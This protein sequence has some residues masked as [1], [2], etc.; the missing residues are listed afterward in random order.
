MPAP[1]PAKM[2]ANKQYEVRDPVTND[3]VSY[4]T[5]ASKMAVTNYTRFDSMMT[6]GVTKTLSVYNANLSHKHEMKYRANLRREIK[7][8]EEST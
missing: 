6:N 5:Y 7:S 2:M 8:L 4:I 3:C 1:A